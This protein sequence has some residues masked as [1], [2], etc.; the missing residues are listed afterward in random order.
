[1]R[2]LSASVSGD[3]VLNLLLVK[4]GGLAS[5]GN[6]IKFRCVEVDSGGGA[7]KGSQKECLGNG[8]FHG[9]EKEIIRFL[10]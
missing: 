8:L 3:I 7:G 1:M 5:D 9:I 2:L 10:K 4:V 6:D